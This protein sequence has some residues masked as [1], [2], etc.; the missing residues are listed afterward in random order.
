MVYCACRPRLVHVSAQFFLRFCS[1][2]WAAL[3][4]EACGDGSGVSKKD[5]GTFISFL[6]MAFHRVLEEPV[7]ISS[8]GDNYFSW[9]FHLRCSC[10]FLSSFVKKSEIR[11]SLLYFASQY[12]DVGLGFSA[13]Q[14]A[15]VNWRSVKSSVWCSLYG[16][17]IVSAT[18]VSVLE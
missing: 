17:D 11:M 4:F 18:V 1:I 16:W 8:V 5:S 14:R 7:T 12:F 9:N 10:H 6:V 3:W 15:E 13:V 2:K